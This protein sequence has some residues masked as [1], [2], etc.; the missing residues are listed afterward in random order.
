M[1]K[2]QTEHWLQAEESPRRV[3]VVLGGVSLADSRRCLL[4]REA[5]FRPV[6]Y[7]PPVDVRTEL[8]APSSHRTECPYKGAATYWTPKVGD[9]A[10]ENGAWSYPDPPP[11]CAAIKGYVAFEWKKMDQWYEE[12][13]EIFVHPRDPYKRVDVLRSSRHVRVLVAGETVA[14][15]SRPWLLFET[16]H[17]TRYYLP[18][19]D[20]RMERLEPSAT[21][22]RCP[23][24]GIAAYWSVRIRDSLFPDL[25]WSYQEPIPECPK[26]KGLFAF[27]QERE[28]EFYVDGEPVAVPTTGW[29]R[30]GGRHAA[31]E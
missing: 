29:S 14:E 9:R 6:Y 5:G 4:L 20:V 19:E 18:R 23:Y 24:K 22:S 8:M 27:F 21:A 26:I 3:R 25:V 30:G 16:G 12:D 1:I 17:P 31:G 15:S 11:E 2:P 10:A 28:A 7:F 13:E